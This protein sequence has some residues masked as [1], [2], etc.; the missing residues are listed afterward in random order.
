[1]PGNT[2]YVRNDADLAT[3]LQ[4]LRGYLTFFRDELHGRFVT[5]DALKAELEQLAPE[6]ARGRA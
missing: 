1:M 4:R 2:L 3:L 5:P 6:R